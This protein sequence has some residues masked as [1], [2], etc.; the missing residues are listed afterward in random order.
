MKEEI[1]APENIQLS[2]EEIANLLDA[3]FKMLVIRMCTELIESGCKL[4]EKMKA[5]LREKRK[6][7]RKLAVKGRELGLKSTVWT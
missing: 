6:M 2:Y 1:K 3:Q 4:D 5:M 7:Y